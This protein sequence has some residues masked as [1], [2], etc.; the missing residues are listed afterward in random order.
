MAYLKTHPSTF[1]DLDEYGDSFP[2]FLQ[3]NEICSDYPFLPQL[4]HFEWSFRDIFH[5]AEVPGLNALEL[6]QTLPD[7]SQPLQLVSSACLLSY[8]YAIEKLYSL[9]DQNED[10]EE[11]F[12]FSQEEYI[13]MFK[14]NSFVKMH[15]LSKNQ[16]SLLKNFQTPSAFLTCLKTAPATMTPEETQ[17][18]FQILGT[19]QIL[20]K[21]R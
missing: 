1:S 6:Q 17:E 8:N 19:E 18:L 3:G 11:E 20:L 14:K 10:E 12:N 5:S 13:L 16:W 21:S 9:K 2:L 4:A 15:I 7:D